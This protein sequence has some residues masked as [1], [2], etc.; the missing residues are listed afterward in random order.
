MERFIMFRTSWFPWRSLG[1]RNG[2][3][4]HLSSSRAGRRRSP[5]ILEPLEDRTALSNFNALTVSDLIADINAANKAGGTNT[6]TLTAP[7]TSPYVLTAVDNTS[8]GATGLPVISG[9]GMKVA[10]DNLTIIGNGDTIERSTASG[11]PDFRLFDVASGSSLTLENLT[12]QNGLA[13]GSGISAQGGAIYNQSTLVLSGVTVQGNTAQGSNGGATNNKHSS[14]GNDAAGGAIW[15]S[16]TLTLENGT[17][18]QRNQ[19]V[20]GAGASNSS[21]LLLSVGGNAFGGGIFVAGGMATLTGVSVDNNVAQGGEGGSRFNP[22]GT[23]YSDGGIAF[24]GGLSV[25]AG[26]VSLSSSTLDNNSATA[27]FGQTN[28]RFPEALGGGLYVAGGIVTLC[29]DTVQ[30]NAAISDPFLRADGHGGGIYIASGATAYIDPFTVTNTINNKDDYGLNS[31]TANIDG[32][33]TLK[34]C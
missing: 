30:S 29:S 14:A 23:V 5:L 9:G 10:A 22:Q 34:N 21:D 1:E 12:L 11:T 31:S 13:F 33:Y 2:R 17:L 4:R 16:G 27:G 25:A 26:T 24:G 28:L 15:S 3:P 32:T 19:A 7:T 20:G 8:D 18:I 6:I